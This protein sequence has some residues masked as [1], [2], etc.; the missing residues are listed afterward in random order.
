MNWL[1]CYKRDLASY[2]NLLS[3]LN[4][5]SW[6][7]LPKSAPSRQMMLS[8]LIWILLPRQGVDPRRND[9]ELC[10]NAVEGRRFTPPAS[11]RRSSGT[12]APR[13]L[14]FFHGRESC[15]WSA[16]S[17]TIPFKPYSVPLVNKYNQNK[18][19]KTLIK[20]DKLLT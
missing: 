14:G 15:H 17:P 1:S 7:L 19:F 16:P 11:L 3:D 13:T 18:I 20:Y 2:D 9:F 6:G 12:S 4:P 10:S 8:L 5:P